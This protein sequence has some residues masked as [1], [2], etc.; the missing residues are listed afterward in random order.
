MF[1]TASLGD[2]KPII[3]ENNGLTQY[4]AASSQISP[5]SQ[6]VENNLEFFNKLQM[7]KVWLAGFSSKILVRHLTKK[8]NDFQQNQLLQQLYN[9]LNFPLNT[10]KI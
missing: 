2:R 8:K 3:F 10:L 6:D 7:A 9:L 5:Q 1:L 4:Y